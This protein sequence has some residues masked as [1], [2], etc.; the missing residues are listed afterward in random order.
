MEHAPKYLLVDSCMG[1]DPDGLLDIVTAALVVVAAVLLLTVG[2]V[3]L[4]IK[5]RSQARQQRA[6]YEDSLSGQLARGEMSAD[7]YR[8]ALAEWGE[9]P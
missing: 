7:Q 1:S 4:L 9:A 6:K 8:E 5:T 3:R 2:A